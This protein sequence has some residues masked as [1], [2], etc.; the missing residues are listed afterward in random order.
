[1]IQFGPLTFGGSGRRA[2]AA[3]TL[4]R[5]ALS[6]PNRNEY[7]RHISLR[8]TYPGQGG[9]EPPRRPQE[10][11]SHRGPPLRIP[12]SE[13]RTDLVWPSAQLR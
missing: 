3:A 12:E 7:M 2:F 11:Q 5:L 8:K 13:P 4:P 1:M 9:T 6:R 10:R